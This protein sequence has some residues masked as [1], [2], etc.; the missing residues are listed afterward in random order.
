MFELLTNSKK[1][2]KSITEVFF[3]ISK[4]SDGGA[5]KNIFRPRA[6]L[7]TFECHNRE[8][9]WIEIPIDDTATATLLFF[10]PIILQTALVKVIIKIQNT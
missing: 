6:Y 8:S 1:S 5:P 7:E 4:F 10:I 9:I 3:Q 2:L